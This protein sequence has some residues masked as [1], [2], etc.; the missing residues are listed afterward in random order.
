MVGFPL[1]SINPDVEMV[2]SLHN[3]V[4][5]RI[6]YNNANT[7]SADEGRIV[8][9]NV[10][11]YSFQYPDDSYDKEANQMR[12]CEYSENLRTPMYLSKN[13]DGQ[14]KVY[15]T[16]SVEWIEDNQRE[17]RTRWDI[18][19]EAGSGSDEVHWFSII[20]AL[21]IVLFLSGMV[22]MILMRS[23]HRDISRYNRVPTE[24][25]RAEER[26]ESGWKLV[27][28]DVFRP[29]SKN[30]MLFCV[31]LGTGSQLLGMAL[32]TLFFA[33]VGVLRPSNR[34]KLIIALLVC[35][36]LL[37]MLAGFVSARTYKM[38]KGK[39]W[40][41]CTVL[42][43]VLFPGILFALFFFL[44]LFVWGAGSDAAV[45]FGSIL[46]VFFLWTFISVP[47][48]FAGAFFGFRYVRCSSC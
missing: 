33:A 37:G 2:P 23:L 41:L 30:P 25:E 17:W 34:G 20:N 39:R 3:H 26:E 42:T 43:G 11:P 31:M 8:D 7:D 28:A 35:F 48:V 18:Y 38:F 46:L 29:P 15:W 32:V 21:V 40:Q 12:A 22:G 24:E 44:N 13:K 6:G 9:F 10:V 45:P 14:L 5:I 47:L 16:Y 1:G 36:V 4:K 19:F 27:H